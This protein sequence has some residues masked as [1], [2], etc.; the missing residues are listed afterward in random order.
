MNDAPDAVAST[1]LV[2]SRFFKTR[3]Q[4]FTKKRAMVVGGVTL[5]SLLAALLAIFLSRA[6]GAQV[7]VS[8]SAVSYTSPP[9]YPARPFFLCKAHSSNRRWIG[10][11]GDC[12]HKSGGNGST[13]D[14]S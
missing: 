7:N 5:A 14:S 11:M 4:G 12:I 8:D 10:T 9:Y 3:G 1:P 13:D 2:R 6:H